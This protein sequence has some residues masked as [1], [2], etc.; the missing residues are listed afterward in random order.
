MAAPAAVSWAVYLGWLDVSG[1]WAAFIGYTVVPYLLGAMAIGEL[2]TDQLPTTPARTVPAQFAGRVINGAF[3]GAVL[4]TTGGSA[5]LG[6]ALGAVGAVI[7]T[8][9]G[10]TFRT[11]LVRANGGHDRPVALVEDAIALF[12]ALWIVASAS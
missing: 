10:Y 9:G 1:T 8:L 3:C 7:G 2:I 4:G 12:G 5:L 6:A 11:R